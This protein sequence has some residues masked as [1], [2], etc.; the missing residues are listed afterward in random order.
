[1]NF[2]KRLLISDD[3]SEEVIKLQDAL[4]ALS[5]IS[6]ITRAIQIVPV[7]AIQGVASFVSLAIAPAQIALEVAT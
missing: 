6:L 1:M 2:Y 3:K 5:A 7:P 4:T